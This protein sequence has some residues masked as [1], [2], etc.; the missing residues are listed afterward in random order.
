MNTDE[1]TDIRARDMLIP[2]EQ[3]AIPFYG[4]TLVAVRLTD[5][6]ICAVLRWLCEGMQLEITAQ[7]RRIRRKTALRDDLVN[8][9]VT[10][11]G[12]PQPMAVLTLHGLPGWLYGVDEMRVASDEARE[13]VVLFQREAT[14]VL[15]QYFARTRTTTAEVDAQAVVPA[16]PHAQQISQIAEQI[17]TLSGTVNLM[18]EHLAAS[19]LYRDRWRTC[20]ARSA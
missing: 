19:W 17:E 11:D 2:V 14:D 13:A 1:T 12:G 4:R 5:G 3:V 15:A 6:R 16:G 9:Q 8:V 10:T 20:V 18:R 7:V